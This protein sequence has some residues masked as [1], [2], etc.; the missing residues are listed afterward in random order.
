MHQFTCLLCHKGLTQHLLSQVKGLRSLC[1]VDAALQPAL[2]LA[3]STP[4]SK[5]LALDHHLC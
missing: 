2:E 5:D 4:T 1:D 3:K